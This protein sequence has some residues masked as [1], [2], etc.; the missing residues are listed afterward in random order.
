MASS[1]L[2]I[3]FFIDWFL[4]E[5]DAFSNPQTPDFPSPDV[6]HARKEIEDHLARGGTIQDAVEDYFKKDRGYG[7]L[8]GLWQDVVQEGDFNGDGHV[9]QRIITRYLSPKDAIAAG[10]SPNYGG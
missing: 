5:F 9:G 1:V 4:R 2:F 3:F 7:D 10:R 8:Q 6:S